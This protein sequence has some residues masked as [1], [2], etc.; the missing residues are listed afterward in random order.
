MIGCH[1]T[2]TSFHLAP[3]FDLSTSDFFLRHT[4]RVFDHLDITPCF[5]NWLTHKCSSHALADA[6]VQKLSSHGSRRS[7]SHFWT[8][9]PSTN[10]NPD[11]PRLTWHTFP[12]SMRLHYAIWPLSLALYGFFPCVSL[13][14]TCIS[15][16][17]HEQASWGRCDGYVCSGSRLHTLR[18]R[19]VGMLFMNQLTPSSFRLSSTCYNSATTC[20]LASPYPDFCCSKERPF[21]CSS[22]YRT[23]NTLVHTRRLQGSRSL[24]IQ[25][26][27]LTSSF[28]S[29]WPPVFSL[30]HSFASFPH[31]S[32]P[33]RWLSRKEVCL[34]CHS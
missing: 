10:S 26:Q 31:L 22:D 2:L 7:I 5:A 15:R 33:C 9:W 13:L 30:Y 23:H 20:F 6:E 1:F 29:K 4:E 25:F 11:E 12:A 17:P 8:Y 24:H 19:G 34:E 28:A 3:Q 14:C 32:M 16:K 18:V 21:F 27:T